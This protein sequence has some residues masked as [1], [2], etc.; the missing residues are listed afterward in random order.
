MTLIVA[1]DNVFIVYY[2]YLLFTGK[3]HESLGHALH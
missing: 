2:Y 1:S 3:Y